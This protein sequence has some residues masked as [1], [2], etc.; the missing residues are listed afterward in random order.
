MMLY[1]RRSLTKAHERAS[2]LKIA[3]EKFEYLLFS[4][5]TAIAHKIVQLY[6]KR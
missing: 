4:C 2:L 6:C 3:S 1:L 5:T